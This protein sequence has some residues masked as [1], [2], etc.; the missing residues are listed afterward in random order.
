MS[1]AFQAGLQALFDAHPTK[2]KFRSELWKTFLALGLPTRKSE[3]FQYLKLRHLYALPP[4]S[5]ESA[6][7]DPTPYI[8]PECQGSCFVFVNGRYMPS[9][10]RLSAFPKKG[11]ALPMSDAFKVYGTLLNNRFSSIVQEEKD[12]F[13]ALNGALYE[14]GLFLY[15][16][17]KLVM[18]N[19]LQIL[20][21][22][23]D[24]GW[25]FPR[26]QCMAGI[27][28]SA[29]IVSTIV[30]QTPFISS[31]VVDFT[32]DEGARIDYF[33]DALEISSLGWVFDATRATLKRDA[34]FHA[35]ALTIG[36]RAVRHDYKV[37]L[38]GENGEALLHG[39]WQLHENREAHT[40][41]LIDHEAPACRSY[42]QFKGVVHDTS[43]SS[44]EGKIYV[45]QAAQKT[46]AFQLNN[47]LILSDRANADSKPNL[48]IFA[49]DVK[50]SHGATVGQ[51]DEEQLLYLRSR[52]IPLAIAKQLLIHGFTQEVV[53]KVA[54][55]SLREKARHVLC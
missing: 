40:H 14:E 50:A 36:S 47:N 5:A 41:V 46:Q 25:S 12:P 29:S 31:P 20:H 4:V 19:P 44:F 18:E 24:E 16:P 49:D 9:L 15:F 8:L 35:V 38:R 32:L 1:E 3:V 23:S 53:D 7:I 28:T 17:P 52:G 2:D 21:L 22:N 48:E 6:S 51:L 42:Q 55:L 43:H 27:L 30:G 37:N 54:I 10:S 11:V 45:R 33:Q 34:I 26:I 39:V 13:A